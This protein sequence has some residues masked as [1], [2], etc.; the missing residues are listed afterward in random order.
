MNPT[1][2]LVL[3]GTKFM[4]IGAL[5]A[6]FLGVITFLPGELVA[7]ADQ[8]GGATVSLP[9][10]WGV[11][12]A[13]GRVGGI[14]GLIFFLIRRTL[15]GEVADPRLEAAGGTSPGAAIGSSGEGGLHSGAPT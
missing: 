4:A 5:T 8:P 10:V 9:L 15:M 13:C 12:W 3:R 6:A 11:C 7:T 14:V 2:G 1:L